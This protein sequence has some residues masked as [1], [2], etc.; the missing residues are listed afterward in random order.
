MGFLFDMMEKA[1]GQSCQATNFLKTFSS[2][3]EGTASPRHQDLY[4]LS[5]LASALGLLEENTHH[6][7]LTVMMQAACRFMLEHCALDYRKMSPNT[8]E[9]N[10]VCGCFFPH[11]HKLITSADFGNRCTAK[12]KMRQLPQ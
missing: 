1:E 11:C 9:F 5:Q 7:P 10:H 3:P 2:I 4:L 12:Y 8:A 6:A